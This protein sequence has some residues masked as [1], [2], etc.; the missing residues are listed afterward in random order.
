MSL[1]SGAQT[2]APR[3]TGDLESGSSPVFAVVVADPT[4]GI[5]SDFKSEAYVTDAI[6]FGWT[7]ISN[8]AG[9]SQPHGVTTAQACQSPWT[10][11]AGSDQYVEERLSASGH[12]AW[13]VAYW[14]VA[15]PPVADSAMKSAGETAG[16]EAAREVQSVIKTDHAPGQ[17]GVAPVYVAF[18]PEGLP[19]PFKVE[20]DGITIDGRGWANTFPTPKKMYKVAR[21]MTA[22][23]WKLF[24]QGWA[25]G[26][27]ATIGGH[28]QSHR[29][30]RD[31][32]NPTSGML[33]WPASHRA[34]ATP[35]SLQ[36][37]PWPAGA[38][39]QPGQARHHDRDDPA[40][41]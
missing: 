34:R 17:R 32:R 20:K 39:H 13:S 30:Q 9:V 25:A 5:Y 36:R 4:V 35:A 21:T 29:R 40:I 6:R 26:V 33:N 18:D 16:E 14:T 37:P 19:C 31:K 15:A 8:V 22:A 1:I 27:G 7:S 2:S 24:A 28:G 10:R 12:T 3:V 23:E 41:P 11:P 38:G